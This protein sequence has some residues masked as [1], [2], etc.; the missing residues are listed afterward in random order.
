[1]KRL[2]DQK[3]RREWA[4]QQRILL[5]LERRFAR[6]FAREVRAESQRL[7]DF[8]KATGEVPAPSASHE[9][10]LISIE[11]DLAEAASRAFGGRIL[12]QGKA[13]MLVLDRKFDF[14]AFFQ[15]VAMRWAA[16]EMVR[17]RIT[18]IAETTR[19]QIV[20]QVLRG[21]E[22]GLGVDQIATNIARNVGGIAKMRGALIART[23]THGAA[24]NGANAA[25]LQTGL[26]LKKEWIAADDERTRDPHRDVDGDIV[27]MD[28][29]FS[30]GGEKLRYPGDPMGSAENTINC[31]CAVGYVVDDAFDASA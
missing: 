30:V 17:R 21:Q 13:S 18:N 16:D 6:R 10:A 8:Y 26:Q 19:S 12:D 14:A 20:R 22:E 28:D 29:T 5:V 2:L 25:A 7:I 23:E 31:R 3:P 4:R 24:N 15:N 1:M 11:T 27:G 9:R